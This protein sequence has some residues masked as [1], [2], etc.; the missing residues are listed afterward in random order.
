[1][2]AFPPAGT[3]CEHLPPAAP[4]TEHRDFTCPSWA[5]ENP[6]V[7]THAGNINAV[8]QYWKTQGLEPTALLL[9]YETG[10]YLRNGAEN[11]DRLTRA[12]KEARKCPR[13]IERFGADGMDSLEKYRDICDRARAHSTKVGFVD[14]A[15][16]VFPDVPIGNYY[17]WPIRRTNVDKDRLPG[18]GYE[19]SGMDVPQPRCY[20]IPGWRG[21]RNQDRVNWGV[22]QYCI[23]RFSR[24]GSVLKEGEI[25]VPWVGYL[26]GHGVALRKAEAGCPIA[27]GDA[28]REMAI[29]TMLRGAETIAIFT[30]GNFN[31]E[32]P[33]AYAKMDRRELGAVML[34]VLDIQQGYD[35]VLQFNDLLRKGKPITFEVPPIDTPGPVYSGVATDDEAI[36]RTVTFG[37]PTVKAVEVLGHKIDLPFKHRGQFFRIDKA[38]GVTPIE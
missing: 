14:P 17:A 34:N 13:C 20:F 11:R 38:G 37:E 1:A 18:Y 5:W 16:Q 29:H 22:F 10:V 6:A 2:F 4:E 8:C 35:D 26:W 9:D 28:Y 3:A 15:R 31:R 25:M 30:P 33:E 27:Q 7:Y 12:W 36:V 23:D 24:C 21:G 19:G 32:L